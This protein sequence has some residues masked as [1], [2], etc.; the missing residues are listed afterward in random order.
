MNYRVLPQGYPAPM[1]D[2]QMV[3]LWVE[4]NSQKFK[5]D[6][7]NIGM[8]GY[9]A[10]AHLAALYALTQDENYIEDGNTLPKVSAVGALAGCYTLDDV[11]NASAIREDTIVQWLQTANPKSSGLP[12][13]QIDENDNV[14]FLLQHGDQDVDLPPSQS[15]LF[16]EALSDAGIPADLRI[17]S[18]TDHSGLI[19]GIALNDEVGQELVAFFKENLMESG[20][21]I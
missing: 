8:A 19:G 10:G 21:V 17:Y 7:S 5:I 15:S 9:S 13:N 12:V 20:Y 1:E 18:Q 2:I 14:S 3:L 16:Y 4:Q 6:I 11:D